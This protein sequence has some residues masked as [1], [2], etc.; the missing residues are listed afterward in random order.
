MASLWL[1]WLARPFWWLLV[2]SSIIAYLLQPLIDGLTRLKLPRTVA[3]IIVVLVTLTLV[4]LII[5][6]LIPS[7][8]VDLQPVSFDL[9]AWISSLSLWLQQLPQ[10]WPGIDFWGVH[11]DLTPLYNQIITGLRYVDLLAWL[12][13][14]S[15]WINVLNET[16]R[17]AGSV[18]GFATNLATSLFALTL[19]LILSLM[20]LLIF[21]LY[22]SKDLPSFFDAIIQL[23][24]VPYQPE[25]REL[26]HR[27]G[28]VWH[29]FFRGQL[30]LS[31]VV[32]LS[33]W[34]GLRII[35]LPGALALGLIAGILEI[36]PNIGPILALLPAMVIALLAGSISHP[37]VPYLTVMIAVVALYTLIQQLENYILVPRILGGSVG[38]HPVFVLAGVLIFSFHFGVLGAFVAAP[39]LA[40]LRT[41]G[42]YVHARLLGQYP[43][44]HLLP[45]PALPSQSSPSPHPSPPPSEEPPPASRP[46]LPPTVILQ[47]PSHSPPPPRPK[48]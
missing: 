46:E 29:A 18:L 16:A 34:V 30:L 43:Y 17:S 6:V 22:L 41:W 45:A 2:L 1:M 5:L 9:T 37:D 13:S 31:T 14:P 38:V 28:H 20:M 32:G 35:G 7:L 36:L 19:A 4:L 23:A 42:E 3:T 15:E 12:P 48:D 33:V 11:I 47:R 44:P 25:W 27:T 40:T 21:T 26:W 10:T 24:P 39:I 8:L